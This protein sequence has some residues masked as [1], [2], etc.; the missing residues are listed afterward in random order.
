MSWNQDRALQRIKDLKKE[1][2]ETLSEDILSKSH[3][4]LS[5]ADFT[6]Y[7]RSMEID[8]KPMLLNNLE[9]D[10]SR[11][12]DGVHVYAKLLD[13]DEALLENGMETEQSHQRLL[14][15]LNLHYASADRVIQN[16]GA[17]RVDYHGGRLHAVVLAPFNDE[18][19]RISTAIELCSLLQS[20][21]NEAVEKYGEANMGARLC[22]G[23]D[24]GK[25]VA[26]GNASIKIGGT[27]R[28]END[29]LF[30]GSAANK[31]AKLAEDNDEGIFLTSNA[32]QKLNA[33]QKFF[34]KS[35]GPLDSPIFELNTDTLEFREAINST[36]PKRDTIMEMW[37]KD[38]RASKFEK[39]GVT[40]F[41]FHQCTPPLS[42]IKFAKLYPSNSIR[43]D[44]C[45]IFADLDGYTAYVDGCVQ[46]GDTREAVRVIQII[47]SELGLVLREDFDGKK[48]RFIGDCIQGVIASGNSQSINQ[49]DTVRDALLC[50]GGLR[51]SFELCKQ[52]LPSAQALGLAVGIEFGTTP[53]S[54]IGV[55]GDQSVRVASAKVVAAS[56][57]AQKQ[58][59]RDETAVGGKALQSLP[60]QIKRY[61]DERGVA[62]GLD[63]AVLITLGLTSLSSPAVASSDGDDSNSGQDSNPSTDSPSSS[64]PSSS[65]PSSSP[66]FRPHM[67]N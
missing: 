10:Q 23:I 9:I 16:M 38:V 13:Y 55:P 25:C 65:P 48:V 6:D 21:A 57:E 58:C 17:I 54:R 36:S 4:S 64:P 63:Y 53:I 27:Q 31:A 43:M 7:N 8:E 11:I 14:A 33:Q 20:V 42:G 41:T 50:S 15:F 66:P 32:Q 67:K 19:G 56:E 28:T 34:E 46:S 5:E 1:F 40:D 62:K 39:K 47:R 51:S 60:P 2:P 26:I 35:L 37:D 3:R 52:E 22:F 44:L 59:D 49:T 24:S 61:F 29:P 12:V 45:S 18:Q 30:L